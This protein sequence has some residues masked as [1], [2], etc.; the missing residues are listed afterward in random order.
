VPPVHDRAGH[1]NNQNALQRHYET[2]FGMAVRW[3]RKEWG[4]TQAQLAERMAQAD[5]PWHKSTVSKTESGQRDATVSELFELARIFSV[6]PAALVSPD[7]RALEQLQ[8]LVTE[9][10]ADLEPDM[11]ALEQL[12]ALVTEMKADLEAY[13]GRARE[14]RGLIG[15]TR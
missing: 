10:K 8:A 5:F 2:K 12:Q 13:R 9:M 14:L 4:L 7:M 1:V 6:P 15:D 3:H 11:R